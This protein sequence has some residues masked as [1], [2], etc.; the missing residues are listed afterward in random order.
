MRYGVMSDQDVYEDYFD[1]NGDD[2][3]DGDSKEKDDDN[4]VTS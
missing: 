2:D 3:E 4:I 1:Y